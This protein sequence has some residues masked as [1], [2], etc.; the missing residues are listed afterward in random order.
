MFRFSTKTAV[1]IHDFF[2]AAIAWQGAWWLRFNL[3]FPFYNWQ[4]SLYILP[5]VLVTQGLVYKRFKL[6]RGLWRFASLPDLWNI[7]RA[8]LIGALSI[9]LILFIWFRLEGVPRSILILYPILLMFLLGGPRLAYRMWK[10]NSLSLKSMR[11]GQR[12]LIVGAGH[13]GDMLVRDMLRD[14][15]YLPVGFID[16]NPVLIESELHGIR[17]MG[18]VSE[19]AN[20]CKSHDIDII[21]I[22]VP[23]ASNEQMQKIIN[24]CEDTRCILRT[25]PRIQDM[26]SGK[27]TLNELREVLIEDLLGREKV[28]LDWKTIQKGVANKKILVTGGGGSIGLELCKQIASLAPSEL[29]IF[30]RSEFNLYRVEQMLKDINVR[31]HYILGD[32]CDKLIVDNTISKFQPDIIFHA[33]AYKHVPILER[34]PREAVTNNVVGTKNVADAAHKYGCDRFVMISTDKAV[35]PTNILG[36]TKRIAEMYVEIMNAR[37]NTYFITVRFGNVL[38]SEGSV[39]PLFREQIRKGGPVTVTHK[40]VTRYFM[41]IPEACQLILQACNM[42]DGAEIYVLDMGK[43]VKISYLA[44]QMVRLSGLTPN[45]DIQIVYIG[46]RPGEK[47][48]EELFYKMEKSEKTQHEKIYIAKHPKLDELELSRQIENL[49]DAANRFDEEA[50]Q[51]ALKKL[52]PFQIGTRDNVIQMDKRIM[53]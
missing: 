23:S 35:N 19:I 47:M 30:E 38:D 31:T 28:Q 37:S 3:D 39:V 22:A 15:D 53:S 41:T 44:E 46:L 24:V 36:A 16:D 34:Q 43:P 5:I 33:A 50:I 7:F 2:M 26:V 13:A 14:G 29:I 17:V 18:E 27:V 48:H 52:V 8:S 49:I 42:S 9:I 10:D 20:I 21:I 32:L 1:I 6:H 12:V 25:L 40:D 51:S 45:K 11:G 4:L